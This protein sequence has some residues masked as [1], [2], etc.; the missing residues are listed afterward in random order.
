MVIM[1]LNSNQTGHLISILLL[2]IYAYAS[3]LFFWEYMYF[4]EERNICIK[5]R[6]IFFTD[7]LFERIFS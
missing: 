7:F 1:R 4:F 5:N 2:A 6:G 3:D